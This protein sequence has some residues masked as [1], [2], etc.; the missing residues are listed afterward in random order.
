MPLQREH[1]RN[2]N[3]RVTSGIPS[4]SPEKR[5]DITERQLLR[6][7]QAGCQQEYRSN[8]EK[9]LAPDGA[10][11][12]VTDYQQ[13]VG[14][15]LMGARIMGRL[16]KLNHNLYFER[17][18]A[19]P[20]KTGVYI[21]RNDFKGGQEKHFICGMETDLNPEFTVRVVGDDGSPK[22]IISGWRRM[23]MRLIRAGIISEPQ[24]HAL[25]GPPSRDSENWARYAN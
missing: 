24:S 5:H 25:F 14:I 18:N 21:L 13:V 1:A 2:D 23:L 20:G 6:V 17:S 9:A 3:Q 12:D 16:R 7:Y 8:E 4:L 11:E 15:P 10:I 22:A 19:D